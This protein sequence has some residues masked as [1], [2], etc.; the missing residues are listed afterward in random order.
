MS[1]INIVGLDAAKFLAVSISGFYN[2]VSK[3]ITSDSIKGYLR[4]VIG[5]ALE[6]DVF[7]KLIFREA[8]GK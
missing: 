4:P 3:G 6:G 1:L 2:L 5:G 7:L 8:D